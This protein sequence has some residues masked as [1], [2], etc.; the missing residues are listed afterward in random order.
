MVAVRRRAG[1]TA[2]FSSRHGRTAT[3]R[4][5]I[6]GGRRHRFVAR[7]RRAGEQYGDRG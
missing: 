2:D 3:H 1:V 5:V 6:V 7:T 4:G